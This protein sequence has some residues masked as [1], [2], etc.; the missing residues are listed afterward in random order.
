MEE[1]DEVTAEEEDEVTAEETALETAL[2]TAEETAEEMAGVRP[3][4]TDEA[5]LEATAEGAVSD[6]RSL[7]RNQTAKK[8]T[9]QPRL[10]SR[11]ALVAVAPV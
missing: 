5:M 9:T 7:P 6:K 4:E 2:E 10:E 8:A 11:I 3:G 1:T